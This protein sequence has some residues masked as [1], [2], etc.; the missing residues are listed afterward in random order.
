MK[1]LVVLGAQWGDEGKGKVV[2]LFSEKADVVVRY[3]GGSNA[4]HTVVIEGKKYVLHLIPSGI[5][6]K[7]KINIIGNGVVVD[8]EA[9]IEE[10][11][12]LKSKGIQCNGSLYIS[13]RAHLIMPYHKMFDKESENKKGLKKIG[14]TG[15][16]I[17]PS[18]VDK[19][20]RVGIR[21]CDIF[22]KESF[23]SK[24]K[25]NI[26]EAN[27]IATKIFDLKPLDAEE[28]YRKYS[29][30]GEKIKDFVCDT[31]YFIN[32]LWNSNK[33]I[34]LEGAQGTMLDVDHGTYPFVTSS[35]S[36]AGGACTGSGLS[37]KKIESITG[38]FKAYCTRVGSGPF[39]TELTNE[40]G[41][42]LRKGGNEYGATTG[43]PRRCGWFD[44]VAAKY[45]VMINGIDTISL[46]KLDVLSNLEKIFI[47]IG[48]KYKNDILKIFPPELNIIE[49]VSP[50]YKEFKGWKKDISHIRN[51]DELPV[52]TKEYL[53]FIRNELGIDYT[54]ISVGSE[55]NETIIIK[56][57]F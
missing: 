27:E 43:R 33:K 53:N 4:G 5:L 6:H 41:E 46:T 19:V 1:T 26:S 29:E 21:V 30:Y 52:E 7:N 47:C 39:P 55:R 40:T 25:E 56:S 38:V 12:D 3:Q 51:F 14:T 28:I 54:I 35:S 13:K 20:A 36:T 57:L 24:I 18:Y 31:N 2:D 42:A 22:D 16:G 8:P 45:A 11:D 37:P 48:Y 17:G 44:M 23:Y 9:L 34:M 10:I 32:E 50:V 15:R 49:K